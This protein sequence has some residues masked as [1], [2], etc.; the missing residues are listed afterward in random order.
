MEDRSI[1]NNKKKRFDDEVSGVGTPL[2]AEQPRKSRLRGG[3]LQ[4]ARHGAAAAHMATR[5]A[6]TKER[7]P[8]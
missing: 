7:L 5:L 2:G 3:V 4:R 1:N 8:G 6:A